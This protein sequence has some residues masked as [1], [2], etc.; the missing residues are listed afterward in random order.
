[1]MILSD[2]PGPVAAGVAAMGFGGSVG[3]V[4]AGSGGLII[5]LE[6]LIG[7]RNLVFLSVRHL[8]PSTLTVYLSKLPILT[9]V[10][11]WSHF[12]GVYPC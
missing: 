4:G 2:L 10:L 11:V 8:L 12:R 3:S 1:M 5:L 9:T 6:Q 7:R